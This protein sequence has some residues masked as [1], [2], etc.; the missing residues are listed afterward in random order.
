MRASRKSTMSS[1]KKGRPSTAAF[2]ASVQEVERE[3]ESAYTEEIHNAQMTISNQE[4]EI[5]RLKT[6]VIALNGKC[7]IVDDHRF[8]AENTIIKHTDSESKRIMLHTHIKE[9]TEQ[10]HT[11]NGEH[12]SRREVLHSNITELNSTLETNEQAYQA[13][14][15]DHRNEKDTLQAGHHEKYQALA[16]E[17]DQTRSN[18]QQEQEAQRAA[19]VADRENV[20]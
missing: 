18:L 19:L 4:I 5:E 20:R 17:Y 7:A 1:P 13:N 14:Y 16:T 6:T 3:R 12:I 15:N 8:H 11:D 2:V 10:I 9:V